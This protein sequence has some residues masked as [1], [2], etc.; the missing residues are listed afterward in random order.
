MDDT[1]ITEPKNIADAFVNNFKF[2]FNTSFP[3]VTYSV[4]TDFL[5]LPPKSAGI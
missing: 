4:R 2:I 3:T 5:S 1:F